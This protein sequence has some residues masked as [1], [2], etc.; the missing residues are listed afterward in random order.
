MFN[1]NRI[2][3]INSLWKISILAGTL[4]CT[5]S[6]MAS[7]RLQASKQAGGGTQLP[8]VYVNRQNTSSVEDGSSNHPFN[9]IAEGIAV[10]DS[11]GSI[12]IHSDSYDETL[13]I[14]RAMLLQSA[15]G[16]VTIGI[17]VPPPLYKVYLPLVF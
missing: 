17:A 15:G 12:I 5:F 14:S 9:T 8:V 2:K 1:L 6:V 13:T 11:G 4:V 10:V 3:E 7:Q 16:V